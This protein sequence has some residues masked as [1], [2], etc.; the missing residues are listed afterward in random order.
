[1]RAERLL[2]VLVQSLV[3]SSTP[4]LGHLG[5]AVYSQT[6]PEILDEILDFHSNITK[7][8]CPCLSPTVSNYY[9]RFVQITKDTTRENSAMESGSPWRVAARG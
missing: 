8:F 4:I 7:S 1:M 9:S 5:V 3:L 2:E 6:Y